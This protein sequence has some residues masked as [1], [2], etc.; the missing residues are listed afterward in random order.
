MALLEEVC[1]WQVA[2]GVLR[3]P[4]RVYYLCI[5]LVVEECSACCISHHAC[6]LPPSPPRQTLSPFKTKAKQKYPSVSSCLDYGVF[7][8]VI[9]K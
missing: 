5:L 2:L 9:E 1:H 3:P 6:L 8:I 4:F 7:I